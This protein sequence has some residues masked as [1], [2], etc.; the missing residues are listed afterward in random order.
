MKLPEGYRDTN[1]TVNFQGKDWPLY[2]TN[3]RQEHGARRALVLWDKEENSIGLVA[4]VNLPE[5]Y[6][7]K[8]QTF[9]K[10]YSENTGILKALEDAGVVKDTG[11]RVQSG[12]VEISVAEFQGRFRDDPPKRGY[13]PRP[14]HPAPDRIK[15]LTR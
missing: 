9:I 14:S 5:E 13:D 3:Y 8:N 11:Q 1:T 12:F 15:G 10:D 6:L 7:R 2:E 4:T